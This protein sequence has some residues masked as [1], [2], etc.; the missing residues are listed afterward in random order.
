MWGPYGLQI[1][2]T[3]KVIDDGDGDGDGEWFEGSSPSSGWLCAWLA[4]GL[5]GVDPGE[6]NDSEDEVDHGDHVDDNDEVDDG[7]DYDNEDLSSNMNLIPP[8]DFINRFHQFI[9]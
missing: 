4:L 6:N 7:D 5:W 2:D 9:Q 1:I 3:L 8:R